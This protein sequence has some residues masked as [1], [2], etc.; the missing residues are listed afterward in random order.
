V[1]LKFIR[2]I[3]VLSL[4]CILFTT[5][6]PLGSVQALNDQFNGANLPLLDEFV[7][8]VRNGRAGELRGI[9]IPDTL[10]AP[11]VQQPTK[12]NE[13][14]SPRQNIVTEFGLASQVGSWIAAL[15]S[16]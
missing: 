12:N 15:L 2:S 16:C 9:Y 8:Q 10:A 3:P 4:I 1:A 14:V 13:F 11:V 5:L 6:I 7:S